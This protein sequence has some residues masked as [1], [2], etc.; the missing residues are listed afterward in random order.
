MDTRRPLKRMNW[1]YTCWHRNFYNCQVRKA[2]EH[3]MWSNLYTMN[4][5]RA[6]LYMLCDMS[7]KERR[8]GCA[9]KHVSAQKWG[10]L[11]TRL[12]PLSYMGRPGEVRRWEW[13]R[14][15]ARTTTTTTNMTAMCSPF[16]WFLRMKEPRTNASGLVFN[17][18]SAVSSLDCPRQH[19]FRHQKGRLQ[20]EEQP[21][22]WTAGRWL[23]GRAGHHSTVAEGRGHREPTGAR[24]QLSANSVERGRVNS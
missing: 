24:S 18:P 6:P 3:S 20:G 8:H 10:R 23:S 14:K 11:H 17:T 2:K 13:G 1:S 16:H 21:G 7:R 4:G 15:E 12:L 19:R 5:K 22:H 9:I